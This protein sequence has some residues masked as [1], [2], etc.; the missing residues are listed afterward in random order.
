MLAYL[1]PGL[2]GALLGGAAVAVAMMARQVRLSADRAALKAGLDAARQ[3][4][5][6]QKAQ[7][8]QSQTQLREAFSALSHEALRQ[9]RQDFLLNADALL[10]PV[11]DTLGKVQ[12]Q[13]AEVD[14]S[15]EGSFR[16]VATQLTQLSGAQKELR[17]AA[18]GLTRSLRSPNARGRWGEI[19]L[20]RIVELAGMTNQCDFVEKPTTETEEGSRLTPDMIVTLP[21]DATVVVDAKVPID[22]YLSAS[23]ARTDAERQ[24][25][26]AAHAR[27][28]R[29]HIRALGAKEYWKQF[30]TSPEFV[31]MFL[32]IEPLLAAALEEDGT[33]LDQAA[34]LRV[35]PATPLTLLALLKAV[36]LGWR[37]EQL[38][39]NAEEI[40]LIGRELYE[41]LGTM[42][43]HLEAV[44]KNLKGAGD[45]YDR[46]VGSLEQKV[47][48]GARRF[49]ELGVHSP[50]ELEAPEQ[51]RLA[52]RPITRPE[53][54]GRLP[55]DADAPAISPLPLRS[56]RD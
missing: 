40:Q 32:P 5:D 13:L 41:R 9:N 33:L 49:K 18:E 25:R 38:A 3:S 44:G 34:S 31:I 48:P 35:I 56:R 4:A 39:R 46:F 55:E 20:R 1:L 42:V 29:D 6:D 15:R 52:L 11:R 28:V 30:K 16:A 26:L 54:T 37:Q 2:I 53:L 17:D 23:D 50:E 36:A 19:Q 24:S 21:G 8:I 10:K 43:S 14:K 47:L 7:L 51:I 45:A 22:A 12:D 27:Q